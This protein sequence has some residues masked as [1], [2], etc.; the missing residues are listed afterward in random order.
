MTVNSDATGTVW[1]D[2]DDAPE[3][4]EEWFAKAHVHDGHRLVSRGTGRPLSLNP[5]RQVTLR[6][7]AEVLDHF[8]ADGRG[9]QTRIN[10]A[11]RRA[12]AG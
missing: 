1:V 6:L 5:K 10:A 2:P 7:D 8:K 3:L 9:W 12:I 11:L 4:S